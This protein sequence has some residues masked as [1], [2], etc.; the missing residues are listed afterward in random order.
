MKVSAV[1]THSS[2]SFS[3]INI[4][5]GLNKGIAGANSLVKRNLSVCNRSLPNNK[6][7]RVLSGPLSKE[8][9]LE[10]FAE[11]GENVFG[12]NILSAG[13]RVAK[14]KSPVKKAQAA[15]AIADNVLLQSAKQ[16]TAM[17]AAGEGAA[18]GSAICP[19][20]GTA[21]GAGIGYFGTLIAWGKTRNAIVRFFWS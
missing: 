11:R 16:S 20:I 12:L 21:I 18:I 6:S 13:Y 15:A 17:Y 19:G 9:I 7:A 3:G 10:Q 14:A 4:G 5:R 2:V 8:E 1:N